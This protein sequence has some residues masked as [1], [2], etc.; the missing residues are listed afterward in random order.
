MQKVLKSPEKVLNFTLC[1]VRESCAVSV[2]PSKWKC[3]DSGNHR[4]KWAVTSVSV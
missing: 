1:Q 4:W 2:L 3:Y